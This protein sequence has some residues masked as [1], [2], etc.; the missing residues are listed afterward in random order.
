MSD[1]LSALVADSVRAAIAEQLPIIVEA[2]KAAMPAAPEPTLAERFVGMQELCQ[3]F[4]CDRSTVVRRSKSE[5]GRYPAL[6]RVGRNIGY[7]A[8]VVQGILGGTGYIAAAPPAAPKRQR[9][10]KN[11][12]VAR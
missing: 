9:H 8:S 5:D 11:G 2:L 12:E 3:I 1:P 4:D 6:L 10:T 7:A